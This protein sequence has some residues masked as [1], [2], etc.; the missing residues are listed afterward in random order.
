MKVTSDEWRVVR[1]RQGRN[2]EGQ[3][4][5]TLTINRPAHTFP[6]RL[7][8][9]PGEKMNQFADFENRFPFLPRRDSTWL[10][11]SRWYPNFKRSAGFQPA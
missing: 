7:S 3:Q 8:A 6:H 11:G 2:A 9:A 1:R 10:R 5:C 4:R